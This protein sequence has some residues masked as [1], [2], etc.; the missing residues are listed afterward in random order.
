MESTKFSKFQR[1]KDSHESDDSSVE[2]NISSKLSDAMN[3]VSDEDSVQKLIYRSN[4]DG[5]LLEW[6]DYMTR[7]LLKDFG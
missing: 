1:T 7:K 4:A 3:D 2:T 5:N 6:I